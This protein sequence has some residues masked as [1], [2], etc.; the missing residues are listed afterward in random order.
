MYV[1][2]SKSWRTGKVHCDTRVCTKEQDRSM[3]ALN[4]CST[5]TSSYNP[6]LA[7]SEPQNTQI[8]P[9]NSFPLPK[10]KG[11]KKGEQ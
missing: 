11:E 6:A 4:Q 5:S 10:R 2:D 9:V 3:W 1:D 7:K 8:S